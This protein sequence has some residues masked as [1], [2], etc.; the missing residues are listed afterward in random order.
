MLEQ[1]TSFG[2]VCYNSFQSWSWR[3][4]MRQWSSK[5]YL[6]GQLDLIDWLGEQ[7][8]KERK[9]ANSDASGRHAESAPL[10]AKKAP[11]RKARSAPKVRAKTSRQAVSVSSARSDC[12]VHASVATRPCSKDSRPNSPASNAGR[13]VVVEDRNERPETRR[14]ADQHRPANSHPFR[15]SSRTVTLQIDA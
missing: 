14:A 4:V 12:S 11:R 13:S 15:G 3:S 1:R 8:A 6:R 10:Q 7:D 2:N 5:Q 9:T